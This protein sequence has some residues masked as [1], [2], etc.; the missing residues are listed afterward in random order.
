MTA[1]Q[2]MLGEN[3][4][5]NLLFPLEYMYVG[6][7]YLPNGEHSAT[8]W[9]MDFYGYDSNGRVQRCPYYA[10][11][12]CHAVRVS[13]SSSN[14]YVIWESDNPVNYIDG[15]IDYVYFL[16]AHDW[17]INDFNVGDT[18]SQGDLLGHTGNYGLSSGDHLHLYLGK[19]HY[20]GWTNVGTA[21]NP[22]WRFATQYHVYNAMGIND[23]VVVRSGG[24]PWEEFIPYVPP[25]P[26][27]P[28]T[29]TKKDIIPLSLVNALKWSV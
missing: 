6:T 27:E 5:E 21:D 11:C 10:P 14:P 22:I 20:T 24:N 25:E 18:R 1:G 17:N 29:P 19:G 15:T 12:S 28:P 9:A 7:G 8:Y 26:P 23:T 3:G 2:K 4:N 16:V 13:K